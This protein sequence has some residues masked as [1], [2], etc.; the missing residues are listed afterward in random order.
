MCIDLCTRSLSIRLL[1]LLFFCLVI[2]DSSSLVGSSSYPF[3]SHARRG[4]IINWRIDV[5]LCKLDANEYEK[6][7]QYEDEERT[8]GGGSN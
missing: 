7:G 3:S 8:E 5:E 6:S 4:M 1:L 2:V